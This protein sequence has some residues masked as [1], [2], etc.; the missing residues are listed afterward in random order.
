MNGKLVL[1]CSEFVT[2]T[3]RLQNDLLISQIVIDFNLFYQITVHFGV[4][5]FL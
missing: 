4:I 5:E 1:N 3:N 2:G